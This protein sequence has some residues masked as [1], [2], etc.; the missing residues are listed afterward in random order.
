MATKLVAAGRL[1]VDGAPVSKP[2]FALREGMTLTFPQA[3]SVRVVRV[4]TLATRRGPAPEA[5]TLYTDLTPEPEVG[6]DIPAN[7]RFEGKGR[8]T[9]KDR[10]SLRLSGATPLE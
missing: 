6:N 5:Q 9:K 3:R 8:P 7:P 4:E 1:R 2:A 10:R